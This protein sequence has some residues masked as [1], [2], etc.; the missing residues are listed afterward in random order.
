MPPVYKVTTNATLPSNLV[1]RA[2]IL[3]PHQRG[4]GFH[5]SNINL[6]RPVRE[7]LVMIEANQERHRSHIMTY[8]RYRGRVGWNHL[9]DQNSNEGPRYFS[10][11]IC[12]GTTRSS[13]R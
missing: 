3:P 13:R 9:S 5:S 7:A 4:S 1:E 12:Q 8:E 2:Q 10:R 11:H 6:P